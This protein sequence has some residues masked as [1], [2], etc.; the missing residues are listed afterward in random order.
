VPASS[1]VE[2]RQSLRGI[3]LLIFEK[4][5]D[6]KL[7]LGRKH[8]DAS[9]GAGRRG[10]SD[11]QLALS[12]EWKH[13][14]G[15]RHGTESMALC[16]WILQTTKRKKGP[17]LCWPGRGVGNFALSYNRRLATGFSQFTIP[18][19]QPPQ[20]GIRGR[21]DQAACWIEQNK[22]KRKTQKK[23]KKKTTPNSNTPKR[24]S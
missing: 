6:G 5:H 16:I 24:K 13:R 21:K 12:P 9:N 11:G 23:K 7:V 1:A 8:S 22:H 19:S 4:L 20:L 3:G 15:F 2:A 18:N 14:V 10:K 17:L